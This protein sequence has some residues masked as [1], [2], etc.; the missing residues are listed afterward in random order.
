MSA[1]QQMLLGLSAAG[2]FTPADLNPR[3]WLD[4][5]DAVWS[6]SNLVSIAN[7]GSDGGS[8]TLVGTPVKGQQISG[9]DT[10]RLSSSAMRLDMALGAWSSGQFSYFWYGAS[11][12]GTSHAGIMGSGWPNSP[13]TSALACF[14][15]N[16]TEGSY[17]FSNG[18]CTIGGST[19]PSFRSNV[20]VTDTTPHFV[21]GIFSSTNAA[22]LDGVLASMAENANGTVPNYGARTYNLGVGGTTESLKGDTFV[23]LVF[24]TALSASDVTDLHNYYVGL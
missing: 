10:I 16:G 1:S 5:R 6:G 11:L 24:D 15:G 9:F 3:A 2:G 12:D 19:A 14:L 4:C 13:G 8:A 21:A 22:Y 17:N 18:C 23:W 7:A 20:N